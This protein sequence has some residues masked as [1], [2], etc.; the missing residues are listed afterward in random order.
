MVTM[1]AIQALTDRIAREFHPD[2]II[3][4]G[5]YADGAPRSDS[6]VDLLMVVPF[7]GN[8]LRYASSVLRRV[9]PPFAV[10]LLVRTPEQIRQRIEWGDQFLQE[11]TER[12]KVLHEAAT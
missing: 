6:D 12:G 8:S 10:D 9:N 7:D 1:E 2:R 5:S 3:L 4:F 11:I